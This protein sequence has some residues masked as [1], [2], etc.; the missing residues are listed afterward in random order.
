MKSPKP[1]NFCA[2]IIDLL[3]FTPLFL[4]PNYFYHF[5]KKQTPEN[6]FRGHL[7]AKSYLN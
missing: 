7:Q 2:Q 1:L 6:A 4:N 5:L 3:Q